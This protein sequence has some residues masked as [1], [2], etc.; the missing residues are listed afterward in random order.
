VE[1]VNDVVDE[2]AKGDEEPNVEVEFVD[3]SA[4][5]EERRDD[6]DLA[7]LV[8]TGVGAASAVK[9]PVLRPESELLLPLKPG[10]SDNEVYSIVSQN[11]YCP[12][13]E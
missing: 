13:L 3:S 11:D 12:T 8:W 9:T 6:K 10:K 5:F 7:V 1:A 4:E 2:A